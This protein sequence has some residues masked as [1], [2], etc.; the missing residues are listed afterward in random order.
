MTV[1][2]YHDHKKAAERWANMDRF[3]VLKELKM[4]PVIDIDAE[5]EKRGGGEVMLAQ[6]IEHNPFLR[7]AL[8]D[9]SPCETNPHAFPDLSYRHS[10][11][12]VA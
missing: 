3:H 11:G 7:A 12:D 2:R 6:C 5:I 4:F 8:A 9:T 10:D 1:I